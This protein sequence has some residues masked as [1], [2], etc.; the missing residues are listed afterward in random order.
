MRWSTTVPQSLGNLL[1]VKPYMEVPQLM[2]AQQNH[3]AL[4]QHLLNQMIDVQIIQLEERLM[5]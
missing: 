3:R 4:L 1:D 5:V 2:V